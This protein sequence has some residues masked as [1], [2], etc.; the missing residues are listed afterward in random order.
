[1][2]GKLKG[3][4]KDW[5]K[6]SKEKIE[7][8]AEVVTTK[9]VKEKKP[10]TEKEKEKIGKK[11]DKLIKKSH[12]EPPLSVPT[13]YSEFR[14]KSEPD[15]EEVKEEAEKIKKEVEEA[16][17]KQKEKKEIKEFEKELEKADKLIEEAKKQDIPGPP[18]EF[19]VG[20][21]KYQPDLEK[22]RKEANLREETKSEEPVEEKKSFF[23]KIK[24]GLSYKITEQEFNEIFDSLEMLLL[25]N[26]VALEAVEDI[27]KNLS[28]RLIGKEIK[29]Q[30]LE[31]EIKTE[32]KN[33]LNEILIEPDNPLEAIKLK[34][35]KPFVI[36][37]FG[38]NG[39]GKTTSIAKVT[40]YLKS[41]G[42]SVALAAGDT[43]RAASIEQISEHADKLKVPLIKQDY[44]TDPAA[45]G[46]DAI[47]YAQKHKI[48]VVLID[49]AGRMHTKTN[50]IEEIKK[51]ERVTKP[52]LKFFV[53]ESIAGNDAIEQAKTFNEAIEIDGTILTKAD[54]DEKGGTII[55]V[56][57]ATNKP[58]FFLG[59][60]QNYEDLELFN[61]Q[62]FIENLGL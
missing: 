2:F 56:S 20:T 35:E 61:K 39:T 4:L 12:Q 15:L 47:K 8:E 23:S 41:A 11:A 43:F 13:K 3:K 28:E 58:I 55:S 52:D 59:T 17:K 60:G 33:S 36:L 25:E 19:N 57:H 48:D 1:M 32:L 62:K 44:G 45:V 29:K 18:L 51:I 21:E 16:V 31:Q 53:A 14:K 50:L 24:S 10:L 40:Y 49:T 7:E 5:F 6:S 37:F 26:N 9:E 30:N 22:I 27:K 42:F 34:Q 54:I 38:I 46:F